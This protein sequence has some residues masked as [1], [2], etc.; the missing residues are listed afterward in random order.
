MTTTHNLGFPSIGHRRELKTAVEAYWQKRCSIDSL[1][2]I[3]KNLRARHWYIQQETGIDWIPVGDFSFYDRMLDMVCMLGAAPKRFGFSGQINLP[4]YFIMAR[5]NDRHAAME[6][7]KWFDTNYHYIV[8]E[9]TGE[10]IFQAKAEKILKETDEALALGIQAKPVLIGPLTF[11]YLGKEKETGFDRLQLLERLIPA[12]QNILLQLK[13]RGVKWVQIEE[14][15]LVQD[16]S[17]AWLERLKPVYERLQA[18]APQLLLTT[19]FDSVQDHAALLKSL[20]V[21]GLH[22]DL[23]RAPEQLDVFL[24]D[25]PDDKI[26]SF[27]VIDGRN[28]WRA[29]LDT[30]LSF[31]EPIQT[32]LGERLWIAPGCS[33][34][35]IPVDLDQE[36]RLEEPL[37]SWLAFSVQKLKELTLLKRGLTKGRLAIQDELQVSQR[38]C[39]ERLS[40]PRIHNTLVKERL[41]KLDQ[42]SDS[43][44]S[45]FVARQTLQRECLKLPPFPTTT[46]GS[47]PQTRS[48][49]ET[50]AAFKKGSISE[51]DYEVA[52][53]M[54]IREAIEKQEAIGLDVFV[55]GEAERNDMVEYFGEQLAGFAFTKYGWVQSY[56]SRCVKPPIIYGDVYRHSPMTV[57]WITYAQRLTN[58]PVKGMLTGPVTILQWSFYRNDQ[59]KSQTAFQIAL[60]IRDEVQDLEEAGIK[61]IQIDEPAY[62]E[63]L[64]LKR[65]EWDEYLSWASRAFRLSASG[66]RDETQIHTHMCYSEFND[67]LPAIA[68]M[69]A[70]VITI[71]SSRS[72]LE[73]LQ[74]FA[75]FHYPNEIGPGVYDVHSPTVPTVDAMVAILNQA[76][77]VIAPAN[78]WVNP[79]CGL[80]T[81]QWEEV[82]PSLKRMVEAAAKMRASL[83]VV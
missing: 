14:P 52:M 42:V 81:R 51:A 20:P 3:G 8:P 49:R 6:M 16:L 45:P 53:H 64:P 30:T 36:T 50:R 21:S 27:G 38:I 48:I 2:E 77:Q 29:D 56:G 4:E 69:D 73:L 41:A 40:S 47:F 28:I 68:A 46:I 7:T 22:L 15:A 60:A 32:Q 35:H 24:N 55:H 72:D 18:N 13:Q 74:G 11:L 10:M 80:K 37:K 63:G 26:L 79:D 39:Q 71:E 62:R 33:L 78:L 54:E 34:L 82:E 83:L 5:G 43:R 44:M 75:E 12:Y 61:I 66:V 67:I 57:D 31:L 25:Y 70:D 65:A 59:P 17:K 19:Y 1:Q 76:A 58:K 9:F 23:V